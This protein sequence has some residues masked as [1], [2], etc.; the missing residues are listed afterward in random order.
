MPSLY[1]VLVGGVE[2]TDYYINWWQSLDI[3][4][5]YRKNGYTDVSIERRN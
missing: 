3:A 4:E 2:V 1:T 5:S